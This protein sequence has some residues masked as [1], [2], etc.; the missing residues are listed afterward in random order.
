[1]VL[2]LEENHFEK[3]IF[4]LPRYDK[5]LLKYYLRL[6]E[7]IIMIQKFLSPNASA[8]VELWWRVQGWGRSVALS[9]VGAL[10]VRVRQ[11]VVH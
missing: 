1:M 6:K 11:T 4:T 9:D 2:S 7:K 3:S 8:T 10:S 5:S